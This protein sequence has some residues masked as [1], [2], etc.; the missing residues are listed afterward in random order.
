MLTTAVF[1]FSR[2]A[3]RAALRGALQPARPD[4]SPGAIAGQAGEGRWLAYPPAKDRYLSCR[5]ESR[6]HAETARPCPAAGRGH[7][8]AYIDLPARL[9]RFRAAPA[10]PAA[11]PAP[12]YLYPGGHRGGRRAILWLDRLAG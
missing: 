7:G 3:I 12:G 8:A 4:K 9:H 1:S 5:N 6:L 11:Y 10:A 2:T